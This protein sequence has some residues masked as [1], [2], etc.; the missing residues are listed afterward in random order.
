MARHPVS[1]SLRHRAAQSIALVA[2]AASVAACAD[3]QATSQ[4]P[5]SSTPANAPTAGATPSGAAPSS[6]ASAQTNSLGMEFVP[7]PAG[8]FRMGAVDSDREATDAERPAHEVTISE[9]FDIGRFEVTQAQWEEVM[10]SNPYTLDRSN[11]YYNLPGMAERITR[12]EHP[13]TVS[14][15]DAQTFLERLSAREDEAQYRLPTEAEWEYAARGGTKTTYSFGDGASQL[16]RYAWTGEGF[17]SGGTHPVG[18]KEPNRLGLHDV[19]GNAWEWV[20]DYYADDYYASSPATDPA[21]PASGTDRVVRGGSWH[22]TGDGWRSS[23]RRD[24]APNYRGISIGF[25]LVRD[26]NNSAAS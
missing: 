20:Q 19:H 15:E 24:Y 10:G 25:R 7:V 4:Q 9:A 5:G 3:T 6:S 12:P 17:Q 1:R 11:P 13:A 14:W 26:T 8:R 21:G 22:T 2:L 23:A 18:L 16:D